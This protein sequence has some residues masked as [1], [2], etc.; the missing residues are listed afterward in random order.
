[1]GEGG[2]SCRSVAVTVAK[3]PPGASPHWMNCRWMSAMTSPPQLARISIAGT[4][5]CVA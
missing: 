2:L 5:P 1:M 4:N 3:R